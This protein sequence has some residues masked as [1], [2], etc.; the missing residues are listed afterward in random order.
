MTD[1]KYTGF[2]QYIPYGKAHGV[3]RRDLAE[4]W[5]IDTRSVSRII[6][7]MRNSGMIIASGDNGYY[8]PA[9]LDE[10]AEYYFMNNARAQSLLKSLKATRQELKRSGRLESKSDRVMQLNIFGDEER[11]K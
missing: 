7:A 2:M 8:R 3:R 4:Q 6:A 11:G 10:L 9:N 5:H 1:T